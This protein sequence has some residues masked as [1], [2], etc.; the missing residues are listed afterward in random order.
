ML[1]PEPFGPMRPRISPSATSKETPLTAV[2]PPKRF[3]SLE[4]SSNTY[5]AS[6]C[7]FGKGRTGS[8]PISFGQTILPLPST[9][10]IT[11]GK[12]RSF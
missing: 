7:P 6:A 12:A 1:L 11:T 3:V 9:N 4:T 8:A 5:C 10:W 2:K